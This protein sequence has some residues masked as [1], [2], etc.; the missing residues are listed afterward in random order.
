MIGNR[1]EPLIE[2]VSEIDGI[3][4]HFD[5][6]T[7]GSSRIQKCSACLFFIE[8]FVVVVVAPT[9]AIIVI[10]NFVELGKIAFLVHNEYGT[11]KHVVAEA[12]ADP[13]SVGPWDDRTELIA[14]DAEVLSFPEDQVAL[15]TMFGLDQNDAGASGGVTLPANA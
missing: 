10:K 12:L 5:A 7:Q 6:A 14:L 2:F 11:V 4:Q 3:G 1:I 15:N 13:Y 9:V 8:W